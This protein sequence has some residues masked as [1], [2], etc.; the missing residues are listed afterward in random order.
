MKSSNFRSKN[1]IF[2]DDKLNQVTLTCQNM[3]TK[4]MGQLLFGNL[5]EVLTIRYG[6]PF[7]IKKDDNTVGSYVEL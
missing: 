3:T 4:I 5:V 6:T 1:F 2:K 7:N